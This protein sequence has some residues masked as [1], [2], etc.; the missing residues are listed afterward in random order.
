MAYGDQI[1]L[2]GPKKDVLDGV[3]LI[4]S[5]DRL[6]VHLRELSES[7]RLDIR[8]R[9]AAVEPE[10]VHCTTEGTFIMVVIGD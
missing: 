6:P 10:W 7:C 2:N 1:L 4:G 9:R 8:L 5:L 3:Q